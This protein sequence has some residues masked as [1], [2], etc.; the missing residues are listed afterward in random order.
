MRITYRQ[1]LKYLPHLSEDQLDADV[2]VE[3]DGEAYAA[4]FRIVGEANEVGLETNHP[5]IYVCQLFG[6]TNGRATDAQVLSHI[7]DIEGANGFGAIG[8]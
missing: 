4:D 5:V 1:L 3:V 8:E 2:T 6:D 7:K